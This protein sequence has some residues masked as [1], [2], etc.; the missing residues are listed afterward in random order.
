[1][2]RRGLGLIIASVLVMFTA[3]ARNAMEVESSYLGGGWFEYRLRTLDDPF[4]KNIT[5]G[6]L[7][8]WPFTNYVED[9]LPEHWTNFIPSGGWSGIMFDGAVAQPRVKEITFQVR[10]SFTSFRRQHFGFTSILFVETADPYFLPGG[11][12]GGYVNLDCLIPCAPGG[13]DGSPSN[14]VSS[15]ELI[16]DIKIDELIH[17]NGEIHGVKFSWAE[18]STVQLEG[19]HDM[20]QWTPITRFFGNPPQSTWTTNASLN[21][22]G[23]FFRLSLVANRHFTNGLPLPT[24]FA[25]SAAPGEIAIQSQQ[26]VDGK[27]RL[28]FASVPNA[29]YEVTYDEWSGQP[30]AAQQVTAVSAV[31]SVSFDLIESQRGGLFRVR[32]IKK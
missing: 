1:M 19:S 11:G 6:Q 9:V 26:I 13:A 23:S 3:S 24:S 12:V 2:N 22:S 27:I 17:T 4:I 14:M 8:P 29:R 18:P 15:I 32:Q 28:G 25:R 10:S 21:S 20:G 16:P 30:L 5:L 31:T 7:V